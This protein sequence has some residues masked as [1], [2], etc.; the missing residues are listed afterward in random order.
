MSREFGVFWETPCN[1]DEDC[2]VAF[3]T[4]KMALVYAL[5][6]QPPDW[7]LPFETMCDARDY[8]IGAVLGKCR[9]K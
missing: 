3:Y 4:L 7:K 1:F 2:L 5:I 8:T 9:D 6:I